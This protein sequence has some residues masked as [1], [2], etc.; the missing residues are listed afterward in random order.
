MTPTA[1]R[2][3]KPSPRRRIGPARTLPPQRRGA[4]PVQA[5]RRRCKALSDVS[6]TLR[7]ARFRALLGENGAGKSTLVKCIM[8]TYRADT[9][10]V[11]VGEHAV[12]LKNPRQAHALGIG[13]VYQHFTLVENMT[14]VENMVMAREHVPAVINWKTETEQLR[15]FMDDDAVP[16]RSDGHGP[17][18]VG[19]REAEGRDPQAALPQRK[20]LI[21]DEPTSVLTPQEADEVLGM[22]AAM[23][24]E[25]RLSVL[26]ITHKFRE[27]MALL[28]RGDGAA[29]R[30]ADRRRARSAT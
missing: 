30:Q 17:Q 13:M 27:V 6:L 25:G 16:R 9:G 24:T 29:P 12:E 22:V 7:P 14:V 8:G 26:M 20:V 15:A 11:R 4:Q 5:L 23:C 28:R 1:V 3:A 10:S 19:R 18:P 2:A 21:L